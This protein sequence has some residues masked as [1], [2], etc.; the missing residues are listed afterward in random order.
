MGLFDKL[1]EAVGNA[2]ESSMNGPMNENE[3]KYYSLYSE[4]RQKIL[5]GEFSAG[6]KLPSKRVMADM[7]GLSQITVATAYAMLEDE[8]YRFRGEAY[9]FNTET[10]MPRLKFYTCN[11]LLRLW[12]S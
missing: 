10:K 11:V 6:E 12:I 8:G 7:C 4:L 3:K 5:C 2:I 9:L 1:K